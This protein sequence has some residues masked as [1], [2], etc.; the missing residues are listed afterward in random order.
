MNRPIRLSCFRYPAANP[1]HAATGVSR[2]EGTF[3]WN[4]LEES[5]EILIGSGFQPMRGGE[6]S[7]PWVKATSRER[8]PNVSKTNG[9]IHGRDGLGGL[10]EGLFGSLPLFPGDRVIGPLG[11][12]QRRIFD[13]TLDENH[14]DRG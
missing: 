8:L 11:T 9:S 14:P 1:G 6:N 7:G 12:L 4:S 2:G 3:I 5:Q 10:R 13:V